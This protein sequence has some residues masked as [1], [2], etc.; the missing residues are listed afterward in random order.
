[1]W[2]EEASKSRAAVVEKFNDLQ[3]F[4]KGPTNIE[5]F[6][7]DWYKQR[8]MGKQESMIRYSDSS[9]VARMYMGVVER[10]DM[11]LTIF[12]RRGNTVGHGGRPS[13]LVILS[14]ARS[15]RQSEERKGGDQDRGHT[16]RART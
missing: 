7:I 9:K 1:V 16:V 6:S 2:H 3:G 5:L 8:I 11:K 15:H 13:Q 4:N 10:H 12:C 14:R